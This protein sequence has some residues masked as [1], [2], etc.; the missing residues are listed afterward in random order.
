[1]LRVEEFRGFALSDAI[2][3]VVFINSRDAKSAQIFTLAHE[4]AHLW[5]GV[6]GVSNPDFRKPSGGQVNEAEILCN[7]VAAEILVPGND[8]R[9]RWQGNDTTESN[10][11]RL[12][13]RYRV[14]RFVLLRQAFDIGLVST[15]EY[16]AT[17]EA[18]LVDRRAV[19]GS[20]GGDFFTNALARNSTTLTNVVLSAVAEGRASYTEAARLLNVKTG[21]LTRLADH[22]KQ[23]A[24]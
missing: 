10:V 14:S 2:A 1:V 12:V 3:P 11:Q 9:S 13:A 8:L 20:G 24:A 17:Y 4:I 5:I 6:S 16:W 18:Y 19:N 23:G 22:M 21:T 7:R 15:N